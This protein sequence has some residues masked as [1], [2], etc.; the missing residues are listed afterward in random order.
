[1]PFEIFSVEEL[2]DGLQRLAP[3]MQAR[4]GG[5]RFTVSL[6]LQLEHLLKL[7][8]EYAEVK[9]HLDEYQAEGLEKIRTAVDC[10]EDKPLTV[11]DIIEI[12]RQHNQTGASVQR[13]TKGKC[14]EHDL[15]AIV[16]RKCECLLEEN[17]DLRWMLKNLQDKLTEYIMKEGE[18]DA[19]ENY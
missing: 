7:E 19:T 13:L 9:K 8:K 1:M 2:L 10:L 18:D 6:I 12:L 3:K 15:L 5:K 4:C 16:L 17:D 14:L 11:T